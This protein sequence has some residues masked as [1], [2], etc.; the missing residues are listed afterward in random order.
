MLISLHKTGEMKS[1]AMDPERQTVGPIR[2]LV[3]TKTHLVPGNDYFEKKLFILDATSNRHLNRNYIPEKDRHY[4]R[5]AQ[6][7]Y[8]DHRCYFLLDHGQAS[9]DDEVPVMGYEWTGNTL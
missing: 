9:N 4:T 1:I 6:F 5:G 7:G 3:Q 8:P 2:I